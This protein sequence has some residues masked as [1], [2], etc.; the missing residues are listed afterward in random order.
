[1]NGPHANQPPFNFAPV[2]AIPYGSSPGYGAPP[3][4]QSSAAGSMPNV[5]PTAQVTSSTPA[6]I[7][8]PGLPV[9]ANAAGQW[10][11]PSQYR[12]QHVPPNAM[13]AQGRM[14]NAGPRVTPDPYGPPP[15]AAGFQT[16]VGARPPQ[17]AAAAARMANPEQFVKN[18]AQFMHQR[19]QP[20]NLSPAVSGRVINL[21]HL[22]ATVVRMG[23]LKKVNAS[24]AWPTVAAA[25]QFPPTQYPLAPQ[26][27]KEHY[28]RN[29]ASYEDAWIQS[30][31]QRQRAMSNMQHMQAGAIN[32]AQQQQP[33]IFQGV[34]G[35]QPPV[36]TPSQMPIKQTYSPQSTMSHV[37]A[38]GHVTPEPHQPQGKQQPIYPQQTPSRT[39][40]ILE[41][42]PPHGQPTAFL[43]A[44]PVPRIHEESMAS[45]SSPRIS[46]DAQLPPPRE[47][48]PVQLNYSP[49]MRVIETY[50]G[51]DIG[52]VG[53]LGAEL[54]YHKPT[55]PSFMELG[56]I[57]I[58]ALTMSLKSGLHAEVRLALDT[59]A[60]VS[61][62]PRIQLTLSNCEDLLETLVDC[63]E[64]Q[65]ELL[66]ENAVEVS[67]VMDIG[68][69]EEVLRSANQ[70]LK[71]LQ[72]V[73]AFGSLDHELDRAVERLICVTTILR[74]LSFHEPN[75]DL[76]ADSTVIKPISTI[77]R[78]MG[79][80]NMLLRTSPNTLEFMKD[81]IIFLSNVSQ[82][83]ELPGKDEALSLLHFLLAF[84]PCPP[85][86][87]PNTDR[88][89]FSPYQPLL[90]NY[91]PPAVDSLAKL[92]AR[93][94]PN[95]SLY[96]AIFL[97]DC[98]ST[99]LYDLLTRTF[100][101]AI[102]P[103]PDVG[104]ASLIQV[105][106]ARK[107]YVV[108]G[109]L[110]AEILA[111][112]APGPETGVARSWLSSADGFAPSLLRLVCL[113]SADRGPPRANVPAGSRMQRDQEIQSYSPITHRGIAVLRRLV[114]KSKYPDQPDLDLPV[115][116]RLKKESLLGTLLTQS[117]DRYMVRELCAYAGLDD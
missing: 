102:S 13:L 33:P 27:L 103:V 90:H 93:D 61:V 53:Q 76:L 23:G 65:V 78:Y 100:A 22:Y 95:R 108:Q 47:P 44:S 16:P 114:E 36:Q 106:E 101:L 68:P 17:P 9:T 67:D 35:Q 31:Q 113:L 54:A 99:P 74:N 10:A 51:L 40:H 112:L 79:T 30:Q 4:G 21:M 15:P 59:L 71:G 98:G 117:T 115:G 34:Q 96:R 91:L 70:E 7:A 109:M 82:A 80:R 41:T 28:D 20:L 64:I 38:N 63:A 66:A 58:H 62:D 73:P 29:L 60:L 19:G 39:S 110:A 92:L 14:H 11:H 77:I 2:Q 42:P 32:P 84:A 26:E 55:I 3:Y 69:Y 43:S 52:T 75:H 87:N 72:E 81:C 25:M 97:S 24:E 1:M 89:M 50:G 88:V 86:T 5:Y 104:K 57:D 46:H 56:L 6:A 45:R 49:R 48:S 37:S 85:P 111:N 105:V 12:Q 94:E 116:L 8:Q 83:I 18:L 107:P